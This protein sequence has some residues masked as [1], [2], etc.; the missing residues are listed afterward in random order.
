MSVGTFPPAASG[1]VSAPT[2]F[3]CCKER[4]PS[5]SIIKTLR[6]GRPDTCFVWRCASVSSELAVS[7][8]ASV[9]PELAVSR[10]ASV[11]PELAVS[12]WASVPPELAVSSL[13]SCR[14]K[15]TLELSMSPLAACC[16][17]LMVACDVIAEMKT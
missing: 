12:R 5:S 14:F 16:V 2:S 10:C 13:T 7:R 8:C 1:G 17:V 3:P 9:P 4:L 11:P 6:E 15:L